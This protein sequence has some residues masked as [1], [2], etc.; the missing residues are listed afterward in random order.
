MG[1]DHDFSFEF[2]AAIA[3]HKIWLQRLELFLDSIDESGLDID[4]VA[5][6]SACA[7]G[8]WLESSEANLGMLSQYRELRDK[9]QQFHLLAS[10]VIRAKRDGQQLQANS[11]LMG[12]LSDLSRGV[13]LLIEDIKRQVHGAAA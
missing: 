10:D 9:H 2:D 12:P 6:P 4:S 8:K 1:A 3:A 11:I 13:V 7:L 5:D